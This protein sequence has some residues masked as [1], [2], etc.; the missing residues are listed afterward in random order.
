LIVSQI[1]NWLKLDDLTVLVEN[2]FLKISKDIPRRWMYA[3]IY[4]N[5]KNKEVK[6]HL[7][8][9][10]KFFRNCKGVTP[11]NKPPCARIISYILPPTI[12]T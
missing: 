12:A 6:M 10:R 8:L 11:R 1:I 9:L 2:I 3:R 4:P 7:I 5:T